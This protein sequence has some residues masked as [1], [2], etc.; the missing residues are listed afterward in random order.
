MVRVARVGIKMVDGSQG[1][2]TVIDSF[3]EFKREV[4][5]RGGKK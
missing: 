3:E 1:R 2:M 4:V 5:G